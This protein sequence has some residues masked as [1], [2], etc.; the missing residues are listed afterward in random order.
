MYFSNIWLLKTKYA[1]CKSEQGGNYLA[2]QEWP[3]SPTAAGFTIK[4][5]DFLVCC[6]AK[7][8]LSGHWLMVMKVQA[9][10]SF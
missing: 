4:I 7:Q 9:I 3:V 10:S 6:N 2:V 8:Q 1:Q 5:V